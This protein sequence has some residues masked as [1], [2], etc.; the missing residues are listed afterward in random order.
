MRWTDTQDALL[1]SG[2]PVSRLIELGPSATLTGMAQKQATGLVTDGRRSAAASLDLLSYSNTGHDAKLWYEYEPEVEEETKEAIEQAVQ[3]QEEAEKKAVEESKKK[4]DEEKTAR[5]SAS[6]SPIANSTAAVPDCQLPASLVIRMLIARRLKRTLGQMPSSFDKSIR[7]LSGG[8]SILQNEMVSDL[9]GE[10]G[11]QRVPD[12]IEDLP[13]SQLDSRFG[14][15]ANMGKISGALVGR[16]LSNKMPVGCN[17]T[18]LREHLAVKWGLGPGRQGAVL[19]SALVSEP[20]A[21]LTSMKEALELIDDSTQQYAAWCGLTLSA[22]SEQQQQQQQ[23]QQQ[24]HQKPQQHATVTVSTS[25][26]QCHCD[27]HIELQEYS[28]Q[29]DELQAKLDALDAEFSSDY[30]SGALPVFDARK[31][32]RYNDWW[33]ADRIRAATSDIAPDNP[34]QVLKPCRP[35]TRVDDEGN[36]IYVEAERSQ[37]YLET[38][39]SEYVNSRPAL[40]RLVSLRSKRSK[41]DSSWALNAELTSTFF[42]VMARSLDT[43]FISFAERAVLITG[44][45]PGSIAMAVARLLLK[46]GA[47]VIVT[48]RQTPADAATVYQQLYDECGS[49]GSELVLVQANLSSAQ[50]C[51]HVVDYIHND[52]KCEL[53]AVIPFAAALEPSAEIEQIGAINELAHRMMLTNIYRLLGR[54]IAS[55]KE[56]GVHCHPTQVIVPLSPNRGT[57]GGDG[58]YSESKLGLEALLYRAESESWGGDYISVCGAIIGWT[59]STRLMRANDI[60]AESVESHGVLTFSAEEMAFN[61][62]A[63]M[64]PAMVELCETQ[65]ILADFGGALECLTDCS[66][67]ISRARRELQFVSSTRKEICKERAL[68]HE[69]IHGKQPT[70]PQPSTHQ[71]ATLRVGFPNLPLS[72]EDARSTQFGLR[73]ADPADQIVVVGFSELGPHGSARTRWEMESQGRLTISGFVEMAWMMGLIRHHN[74][75]R[76]DGSFYVGWCDAKTGA[77]IAEQDIEEKYGAYIQEHTGVRR[78]LKDDI[79]EWDPE[80]RQVLEET[81]LTQDLPEFEVSRGSAEALKSKHGD[82]VVVRPSSSEDTCLVRIRRGTSIAILKEVPFQ[83]G[84]VAGL[85]PKGWDAQRYGV[86][87]D[88]AQALEPSTL[89]TLCCVA[90]AFYSAGLPDPTEIFAHM[91]VAEFGNFLGTLMGGSSKVKSLYRDMLLDRPMASD[92]LADSFANTPAAWVNM[93]LLGASGPIKTPSGACATSIESIDSAVDSIRSGKTKMCLVGG[94]DD[95]QEDESYGFSMLKATVNTAEEAARGRQPHEMSRPLTESRAGFV[96]SHGCGVQLICRA[97]VAIEMGLPIYGVIAGST[98]AADTVG[99]SIPA[100]GQGLLTFARENLKPLLDPSSSGSDTSTSVLTGPGTTPYSLEDQD[101]DDFW[102]TVSSQRE[103]LLSPMRASLAQHHLTIDDVDFASLHATSTKSGDLNEF[104]VISNQLHHLGRTTHQPLWTV[105]QKALTGHPKAPAAAW[106]LNGCLQ[107]MRDGTL[108]A[109][110]NADNVDPALR[111]F[112]MLAVPKASMP[113]PDPKAFLVT[114]FGFGQKSGQLVGVSPKYVYG[115]LSAQEYSA[116][117]ARTLQRMERADGKYARAV[118]ENRIVGILD[119]APY[120]GEN[121]KKVLLDPDSRAVYDGMA[122]TWRFEV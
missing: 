47:K 75:R 3:A 1:A 80:K 38:I 18:F 87:P 106:M 21:R 116:Y 7:D 35:Q 15:M 93:L 107:I 63:M 101:S 46:S 51:Q 99:R 13:L 61:V 33:N 77:P 83:A 44:A 29:V 10:F 57:F 9:V 40:S 14:D 105:C 69:L 92:T 32:R 96:E 104:K 59:R 78:I 27:S 52:M 54:L 79:P 45:G 98:M 119:Y 26:D 74:E 72:N 88:L 102:W 16:L 23:Q 2:S 24:N 5:E 60:V 97:S 113:L 58:L 20:A 81:V 66:E 50:D 114:S 108:P 91:H 48:T 28:S 25:N 103:A 110:R 121:T 118:M 19:I 86:P 85:I 90:E 95:L 100:P 22:A 120:D 4:A 70:V 37:G 17:Q 42:S 41:R 56:R 65:P 94:Y 31:V 43:G 115:L 39:Q 117:R 112:S 89:F 36:I 64:D 71:R 67:V 62:V 122:G 30:L 11:E 76:P 82:N 111:S 12:G 109:N 68:E 84:V 49:A 34:Q 55:Q 8:K 53:D 73:A 6:G